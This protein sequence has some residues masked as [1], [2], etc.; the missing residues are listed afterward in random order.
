MWIYFIQ[1]PNPV[2]HDQ[3]LQTLAVSV[4]NSLPAPSVRTEA[5]VLC[6]LHRNSQFVGIGGTVFARSKAGIVGS[7]PTQGMDA[8]IV[9]F[10]C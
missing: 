1:I 6:S 10:F 8:W 7:N 9:C 3:A 5:T 2:G 4:G